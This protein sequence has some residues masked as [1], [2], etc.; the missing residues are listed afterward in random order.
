MRTKESLEV[1]DEPRTKRRRGPRK[2]FI[3]AFIFCLLLLALIGYAIIPAALQLASARRA[4]GS[5]QSL[6]EQAVRTSES[7]ALAAEQHLSGSP[8]RIASKLPLIG[9]N[10]DALRSIAGSTSDVLSNAAILAGNLE[11]LEQEGLI[12]DARINLESLAELQEPL[13][14]TAEQLKLMVE[15]LQ[16]SRSGALLPPLWD[17]LTELTNR[18]ESSHDAAEAAAELLQA[19]GPLLGS[20]EDRTYL[21]LL[22]NNSELRG[23]G[24]ILAGAGTLTLSDGSMQ[25]G[26]FASAHDLQTEPRVQVEAPRAYLKRY[27]T[28]EANSTL[29]LNTTYSPDIPDVGVVSSRLFEEVTGT[30]TDGVIVADPRGFSALLSE[31]ATLDLPTGDSIDKESLARF[32]YSDAYER[33]TDQNARRAFLVE[34]GRLAFEQLLG[35]G[36]T[37]RTRLLEL[38]E[39]FAGGHLRFNSFRPT[40][41][42]AL[43][44][45]GMTGDL[46]RDF[47]GDTMMVTVQNRGGGP[48]RGSKL[49]Y[50][51][52]RR[53]THNCDISPSGEAACLTRVTLSNEVPVGLTRYVAG[54]PYG[55]L[56]SFVEVYMPG[57]ATLQAVELGDVPA[58]VV[59]E[60]EDGRKTA[61]VYVEIAPGDSAT[62]EVRY[63]VDAVVGGYELTAIPQPLAT[64][65]DLEL[66]INFP[67]DWAVRGLDTEVE[68][69]NLHYQGDFDR[70][71]IIRARKQERWGIPRMWDSLVRFWREP[72]L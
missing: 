47:R 68:Q 51:A 35:R 65:A 66:N 43:R 50:W 62:V 11:T 4:I 15:R 30:P 12:N 42:Q 20:E 23:A 57:D 69:E 60:R 24:G 54:T 40:E 49:D 1:A 13:Q 38:G 18:A 22:L 72:L 48:G 64:D 39:A 19:V 71:V 6:N 2:A 55:L 32:A 46:S 31:D 21:V 28:Y 34:L 25:L 7:H 26:S 45:A 59:V 56:R 36:L 10:I 8:A 61:G 53:V 14:N 9:P 37:G 16:E 58:G 29:W 67:D 44:D 41:Q 70:P 5:A 27:G 63:E 52:A 33:F 3:V 17:L